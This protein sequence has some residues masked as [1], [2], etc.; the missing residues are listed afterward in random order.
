MKRRRLSV[1]DH[2][3]DAQGL[4]YVYA[5]VSR[6]AR[7][8]S[9]GINL[10]PNNACNW[11]CV[12]CQVP[13]LTRGVGPPIDLELFEEELAGMVDDIVNGDF[14]ERSAPPEARQLRDVAFSGNGEPTTSPDF[15]ESVRLTATVLRRFAVDVPVTLITNGS[16][17]NKDANL[18]ALDD[19]RS[20]NGRV[21]FKL[22]AGSATGAARV[23]GQP[24]DMPAHLR[25]LRRSAERCPT[26]I[27]TCL[28]AI[29]GE[30]PPQDELEAY[31]G[32]LRQLVRDGVA[33]EGV[34]LYTLARPSMQPEASRLSALP[35][36]W[37]DDFATR[38]E[39]LGLTVEV[40]A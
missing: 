20:M 15:A 27:Q 9:L 18:A 13:D 6:R 32:H 38:L 35:R 30:P 37:L 11:Q 3:R 14:L 40:A 16:M 5:V 2:D 19:L 24:I 33:L 29:D 23:N 12:Y 22:D 17:L 4:R 1:A 39:T 28:F 7:G 36:E 26:W 21:W 34:H 10:N 8:V 25:R 31:L